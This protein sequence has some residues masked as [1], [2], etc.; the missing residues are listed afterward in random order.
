MIRGYSKFINSKLIRIVSCVDISEL[1]NKEM[2]L[3]KLN[4]E[5]KN[6]SNVE[7]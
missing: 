6:L 1:K 3:S 5:L 7:S 2:Q 4:E